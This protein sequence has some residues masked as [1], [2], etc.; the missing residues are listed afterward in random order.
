M[1]YRNKG[2]DLGK[3]ESHPGRKRLLCHCQQQ[4][5]TRKLI[6]T[7]TNIMVA[8]SSLCY[9]LFPQAPVGWDPPLPVPGTPCPQYL[10]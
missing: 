10:P 5:L 6:M 3:S 2:K 1:H 8:N 4:M 7:F 9:C